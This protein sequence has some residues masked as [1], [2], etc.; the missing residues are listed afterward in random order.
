MEFRN[1]SVPLSDG[2][3]LCIPDNVIIILTECRNFHAGHL[4]YALRRRMDYVAELKSDRDVLEKYYDTVN[5][6]A[7]RIIIDIFDS[8]KILLLRMLLL[9]FLMLQISICLGMVCS[10]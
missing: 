2:S 9:E 4:D 6:N 1:E 5:A 10:W 3:T 8:I 7:G